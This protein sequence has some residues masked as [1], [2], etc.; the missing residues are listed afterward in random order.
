MAYPA[1]NNTLLFWLAWLI[2]PSLQVGLVGSSPWQLR[3]SVRPCSY[4]MPCSFSCKGPPDVDSGVKAYPA[5]VQQH[6]LRSCDILLRH[7]S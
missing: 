2:C 3:L 5:L 1:R 6:A 4:T 7:L